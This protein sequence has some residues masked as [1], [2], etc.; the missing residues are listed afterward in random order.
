MPGLGSSPYSPR[1][2]GPNSSGVR[3]TPPSHPGVAEWLA[4]MKQFVPNTPVQ[5]T[6]GMGWVASKVFELAARN[7]PDTPTSQ[8][9]LDGLWTIKGNDMGGMTKP[10]TYV[11]DQPTSRTPGCWFAVQMN[12]SKGGWTGDLRFCV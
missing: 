8:A 5:P 9:V 6:G 12:D 10:L 1:T 11:K 7:M 3:I 2:V 4:A